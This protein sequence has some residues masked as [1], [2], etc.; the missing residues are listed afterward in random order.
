MFC[1]LL[2]AGNCLFI[3]TSRKKRDSLLI[4]SS[5]SVKLKGD[6]CVDYL[7]VSEAPISQALMKFYQDM[8]AAESGERTSARFLSG[9][10]GCD[11]SS[12]FNQLCCRFVPMST[13][14]KFPEWKRLFTF[15]RHLS[16][17]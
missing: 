1:L 5:L 2:V 4:K 7:Q 13:C 3:L 6:V 9:V 8:R 12:L 16:P 15:H 17:A 14:I 10:S 11:P